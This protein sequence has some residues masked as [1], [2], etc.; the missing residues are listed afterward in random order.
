MVKASVSVN[1]ILCETT[2]GVYLDELSAPQG[3]EFGF[4]F[5][6]DCEQAISADSIEQAVDYAALTEELKKYVSS[7]KL[8]L[9]ETLT[10]KI[11]EKI[12]EFSPKIT[13][14]KVYC[15]K[16]NNLKPRAEIEKIRS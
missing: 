15:I 6:Y 5:E 11:A 7:S 14:A 4:E 9:L 2:I 1:N 3:V 12:L 13:A 10:A 8:S 16:L